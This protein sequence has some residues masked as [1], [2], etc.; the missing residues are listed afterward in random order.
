MKYRRL[1][2][3]ELES[4][5]EDFIQFL[6]ANSI[7][8]EDWTKLKQADPEASGQLVDLFSD[9]VWDKVLENVKYLRIHSSDELRVLSF[10]EKNIEMVLIRI[11]SDSFDF[12]NPDDINSVAEGNV[13]LMK[14][15]PEI[16]RGKK[17]Y[18]HGKKMEVFV[19]M[20]QGAKPC[21]EVFW[22][23]IQS[24]LPPAERNT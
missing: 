18:S 12:T 14:F 23:S 15:E 22:R 8:A 7:T 16:F 21:K 4:L 6:A 10:G 20:E 9:M 17:D 19:M 13:D 2:P 3:E 5:R 11:T 24:M 1:H